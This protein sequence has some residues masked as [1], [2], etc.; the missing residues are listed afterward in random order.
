MGKS[1]RL[2]MWCVYAVCV[3]FP[4][5]FVDA[6]VGVSQEEGHTGFLH[7]PSAVLALIFIAKRIQPS[8]SLI[9]REVELCLPTN[10]P[11]IK[12]V[13]R[14]NSKKKHAQQMEIIRYNLRKGVRYVN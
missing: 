1:F 6:S 10:Y 14:Q 13:G 8:L 3:V 5:F 4:Q 2:S 9:D 11:R 12:F 7:R